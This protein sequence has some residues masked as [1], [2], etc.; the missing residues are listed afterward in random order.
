MLSSCLMPFDGLP[1]PF[2]NGPRR[3]GI[4][5]SIGGVRDC[6]RDPV[7]QNES[8]PFTFLILILVLVLSHSLSHS[9][10]PSSRH[11]TVAPSTGSSRRIQ[12]A[13][14]PSCGGS[15]PLIGISTAVA[16][17]SSSSSWS[18]SMGSAPVGA[19]PPSALSAL[20]FFSPDSVLTAYS[21]RV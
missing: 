10:S 5:S 2:I 17:S 1:L 21:V 12:L 4:P 7:S 20:S 14:D 16:S 15:G 9:P 11:S 18:C 19:F 3:F 13:Q 8:T 6:G